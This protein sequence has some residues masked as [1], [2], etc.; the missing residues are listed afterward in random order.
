MKIFLS[1][2]KLN[3]KIKYK[4]PFKTLIAV[5]FSLRMAHSAKY[6]FLGLV[7]ANENEWQ[8]YHNTFQGLTAFLCIIPTSYV[9]YIFTEIIE[10]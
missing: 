3:S 1:P 5:T 8:A 6:L 2:I 4:F 10:S 7:G 9:Q